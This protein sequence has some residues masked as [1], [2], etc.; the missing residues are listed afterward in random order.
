[1]DS[2]GDETSDDTLRDDGDSIADSTGDNSA[3]D[4]ST[5]DRGLGDSGE[6]N[7]DPPNDAD[8]DD[9]SDDNSDDSR[10]MADDDSMSDGTNA[11]DAETASNETPPEDDDPDTDEPAAD[12]SDTDE[13]ATDDSGTTG[14]NDTSD[15]VGDDQGDDDQGELP[16]DEMTQETPAPRCPIEPPNE[17]DECSGPGFCT[18]YDC[19]G[20]GVVASVCVDG[21]FS[22]LETTPCEATTCMD[23]WDQE[24]TLECDVGSVCSLYTWESGDGGGRELSCVETCEGAQEDCHQGPGCSFTREGGLYCDAGGCEEGCA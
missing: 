12:D 23:S 4:G 5:D 1:M 2:E 10:G 20:R 11:D 7:D 16:P 24:N 21:A 14:Q 9:S 13:P 3:D 15:D 6:R 22:I 17:G 19:G 8:S 18:Y